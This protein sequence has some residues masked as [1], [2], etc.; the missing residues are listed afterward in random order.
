MNNGSLVIIVEGK[1]DR[2]RLRNLISEDVEI[3]CTFGT[4]GTEKIEELQQKVGEREVF[5]FTDNDIAGKKIRA[6]LNDSFPD[7]KQ[8]YTKRGYA[9]VEGT[10][11]EWIITQ[12]EKNGLETYI[13]YPES[14]L[15]RESLNDSLGYQ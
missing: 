12:L 1:N 3:L 11:I 13:Q 5:I 8:L 4:P 9:G 10:P 14:P 6:L 15:D 7:A 2:N